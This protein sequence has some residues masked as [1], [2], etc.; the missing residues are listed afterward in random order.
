M[1]RPL[2]F[3]G[4]LHSMGLYY[5]SARINAL[6]GIGEWHR[7]HQIFIGARTK[8]AASQFAGKAGMSLREQDMQVMTGSSAQALEAEGLLAEG[9]IYVAY[10]G[11]GVVLRV[12]G[13][14]EYE[15]VGELKPGESW[16]DPYTLERA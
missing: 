14:E 16:R 7:Q 11:R 4:E 15:T 3:Y 2:K 5:D 13:D 10:D 9:A 8:R 6:L 12:L 1:P